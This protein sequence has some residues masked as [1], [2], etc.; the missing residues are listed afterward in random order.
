MITNII[1]GYCKGK[2]IISSRVF[3][4][5]SIKLTKA[6]IKKIV[7]NILHNYVTQRHL[8][9]EYFIFLD[10]CCGTGAVGIEAI[11]RGIKQ[12]FFLDADCESLIITRLNLASSQI[13]VPRYKI[14]RSSV[15]N[16]KIKNSQ[17]HC[18][19]YLDLPYKIFITANILTA[20]HYALTIN[21]LLVIETFQ[22]FSLST[23]LMQYNILFINY[24]K[25][26]IILIIKKYNL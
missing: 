15:Y 19:A 13:K 20:L 26:C 1:G 14:I 24:S 7:F 4:R 2:K 17:L 8:L 23:V 6:Y 18:I 11:S 21:T 25:N 5:L 9:K 10:L 22:K 16:F 12:V 3:L